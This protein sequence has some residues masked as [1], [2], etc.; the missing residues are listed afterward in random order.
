M[1]ISFLRKKLRDTSIARK[2][3]FT[4]GI[5]TLLVIVEM[6]TLWFAIN[7][8]SS[9][10]SYVAGEGLWSKAQKDA[11]YHMRIYAYSHDEKDYQAFRD[12]L[13]VP[14]GDKKARIELQ[15]INP[16]FKAARQGLIEGRNNPDDV[17]G[18]TKLVTRFHDVYYINRALTIWGAAEQE[19]EKLIPLGDKLHNII[20]SKPVD[21]AEINKVIAQTEVINGRL[22]KLEDNF[23]F[24]LGEGAR[25]LENIVL[26]L[27]L[28]LSL[29]IGTT[30]IIIAIS[31]S[32]GIEK[33]LKAIINGAAFVQMGLLDTR[34][35]VYSGDEIGVL[36][37][38]F[39]D[40]TAT[41]QHNIQELKSTQESLKTEKD[42]TVTA[43]NVKRIFLANMTHEI[44]TPMNAI[45][46][47][48]RLLEEAI[49]N[50]EQ[51][52]YIQVIIK[53]VDDLLLILNDILD[54]SKVE[55]GEIIFEK[56]PFNLR[57]SIDAI[58]TTMEPKSQQKNLQ[59]MSFVDEGIP[60]VVIGDSVRLNQILFNLVSNA[61]KYT[62]NGEVS[63]LVG[64]AGESND[65]III[66]FIVKDTG[67]GIPIEKQE[68]IFDSIEQATKTN[69]RRFGGTKLG[70]NIVK[71]LVEKHDGE[72]FVK[73]QPDK[74]TS[75]H[76]RLSFLKAKGKLRKNDIKDYQQELLALSRRNI[77]ILIVED[78]EMNQLL[79]V[80]V[81]RNKGYITDVAENGKIALEKY[82]ANDYD[83]ILMDIQMPE[84]DGYETTRNIR[85]LQGS[86]RDIPIIAMTA[87]NIKG[88]L[89]RCL[90]MGMNDYI[91]KPFNA[92][93]LYEKINS[94][95]KID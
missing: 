46:G 67:I 86:K 1:I 72:I 63:I 35:D 52:E 90:D 62:E 14:L 10:R 92:N 74:G 44:R 31:V 9:V 34:V 57:D 65:T 85:K 82:E 76:F 77:R 59:L 43:E 36:A 39:N 95:I 73:S 45:V 53:S 22:T 68:R 21:Q 56:A 47:F 93:E 32:R 18:M 28:T 37:K 15:K 88:E 7:T 41:L 75:F 40:M 78:N 3:Y 2:L 6:C 66:E 26:T 16:D 17:D 87:R 4:V 13:N 91:P 70:L 51:Q 80:K 29:T 69:V 8:L 81:L 60:D 79:V 38:T 71:L 58:V 30:S 48:A 19:M 33:G 42:R 25:W 54:F 24:T 27:L 64:N 94:L 61:L 50:K 83:I 84:M 49:K 20:N 55:A 89:K 5:L 12:F 23:S 11:V